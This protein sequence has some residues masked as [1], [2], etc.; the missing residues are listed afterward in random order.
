M[1]LFCTEWHSFCSLKHLKHTLESLRITQLGEVAGRIA[2][3]IKK[4]NIWVRFSRLEKFWIECFL[5]SYSLLFAA[6][7]LL[8]FKM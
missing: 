8:F 7:P 3:K 2:M 4:M 1:H 5:K 6:N